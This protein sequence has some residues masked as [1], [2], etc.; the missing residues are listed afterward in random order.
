MARFK[1]YLP[2]DITGKFGK[3][4]YKS[5]YGSSYIS[6]LP[7][8]Y[9]ANK[10]EAALENRRK[11]SRRQRLNSGL[12]KDKRLVELW[13][14]SDAEGLNDN[15]KMMRRNTP[16]VTSKN[17]LPGLG[18]TP[19]SD[20][21]LVVRKVS[22]VGKNVNFEF[23]IN[24]K[25]K[26]A[27]KTPYDICCV[28]IYDGTHEHGVISTYKFKHIVTQ[29]EY[30]TITKDSGKDFLK[31]SILMTSPETNYKHFA[32]KILLMAAAIKQKHGKKKYEWTET[33]FEDIT[34]IIPEN[35]RHE[36]IKKLKKSKS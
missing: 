27:F 8:F 33:F 36:I 34:D 13:K 3:L 11:F 17:F 19:H 16:F 1:S 12:R 25:N 26:S 9:N 30:L 24:R 4:V 21:K 18:F 22:F 23:K 20:N 29:Y 2:G 6:R 15:A 10:T 28:I 35:E 7:E 32:E 31:A 5:R 14:A